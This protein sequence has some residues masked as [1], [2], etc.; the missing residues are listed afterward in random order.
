MSNTIIKAIEQMIIKLTIVDL[1]MKA[2]QSSISGS[3][4]NISSL[5]GSTGGGLPG[6][7][8]SAYFGASGA[9]PPW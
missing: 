5:F 2:L 3:G 9:E 7:A 1:L 6:T 4:F 8:G